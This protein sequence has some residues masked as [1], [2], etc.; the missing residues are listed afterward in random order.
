[1][2][3]ILEQV[4]AEFGLM[5]ILDVLIVAFLFYRVIV[6]IRHTRAMTLIKGII[7]LVLATIISDYLGLGTTYWILSNIWTVGILAAV[8]VFQPE[9]R[10]A[11]EQ[12]GRGKLFHAPFSSYGEADYPEVVEELIKAVNILAKN[13]IGALIV[14]ER[15]TGIGDFMET[16]VQIDSVVSSELL[17]NIFIPNTPLHDGAVM[18]RG[19]RIVAAACY[20][21]L[22]S[23]PFIAK[24]VGS[25]HRAALGITEDTDALAVVVSEELGTIALAEEGKMH[26]R[27]DGQS[28]RKMLLVGQQTSGD[29]RT[30]R[31][32]KFWRSNQ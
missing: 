7:A 23:S 17:L 11:L 18:I 10:R 29:L 24:E 4:M 12:L 28:L 22:A 19:T 30:M 25:R 14:I 2:R 15:E 26:Q 3:G 16:G 8:V 1:M 20:L 21:P 27:L 6:L 32:F 31:P 9:L 13:K 5:D